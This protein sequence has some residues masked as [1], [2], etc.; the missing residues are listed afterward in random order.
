[1][2]ERLRTDARARLSWGHDPA[3][4]RR[5]L[6]AKGVS[7]VEAA[8]FVA[9]E[10]AEHDAD[11]RR[12]GL[13]QIGGAVVTLLVGIGVTLYFLPFYPFVSDATVAAIAAVMPMT[14]ARAVPRI[15]LAIGPAVTAAGVGLL[16][17]GLTRALA[18]GREPNVG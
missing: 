16:V 7:S 3:E 12:R 5:D 9:S 14:S 6:E 1:M 13:L 2:D 11:T 10:M 15:L 18:G 4:V 8:H 17:R